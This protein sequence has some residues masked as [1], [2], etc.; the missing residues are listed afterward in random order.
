MLTLTTFLACHSGSWLL[1]GTER[2]K[3]RP[4]TPLVEALSEL[5]ANIQYVEKVGFLPL[6]IEGEPLFGGKVQWIN[7]AKA[8]P[9]SYI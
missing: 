9:Q 4:V 3:Q 6:R 1:T 2:M 8:K 7:G 5:G